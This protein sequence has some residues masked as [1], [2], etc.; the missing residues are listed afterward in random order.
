[1]KMGEVLHLHC[2][3]T[4]NSL[5]EGAFASIVTTKDNA[6]A[7]SRAATV[8][9]QFIICRKSGTVRVRLLGWKNVLINLNKMRKIKEPDISESQ[10]KDGALVFCHVIRKLFLVVGSSWV[11]AILHRE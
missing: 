5:F 1:M 10:A 9:L 3:E 6:T 8:T 4:P 7:R 11:E 2:G